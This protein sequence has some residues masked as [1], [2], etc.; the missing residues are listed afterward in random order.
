MFCHCCQRLNF[1]SLFS[2]ENSVN[3]HFT[4]TK[5]SR[6][7]NFHS[8]HCSFFHLSVGI[9]LDCCCLFYIRPSFN[10]MFRKRAHIISIRSK[11]W[12]YLA[13]KTGIK[14]KVLP[15]NQVFF[16]FFFFLFTLF[17]FFRWLCERSLSFLFETMRF[18]FTDFS[19]FYRCY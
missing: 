7:A 13:I 4:H 1:L 12:P 8:F 17:I 11:R 19:F 6:V 3:R 2:L 18:P 10:I 15:P 16:V 9:F 5:T 14:K